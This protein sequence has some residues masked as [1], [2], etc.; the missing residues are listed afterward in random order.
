LAAVALAAAA[1]PVA[2]ASAGRAAPRVELRGTVSPLVAK[3]LAHVVGTPS[4]TKQVQAVV[5]FK[6]RN[7]ILLHWL[8]ERSSGRLGM[9]NAEI[10][11][12]FAP[13][14]ATVAAVRSYVNANGLSV[15][16]SSD[17]SLVVSGTAAAANRAFGVGLRLYRDARGMTYQAPS[18]NVRL[19]KGIASVV[20][21]VDGLDTSLR[22]HSH[23]Q[24]AS[25]PA[26]RAA[27]PKPKLVPHSVAG[28]VK[29]QTKQSNLGLGYLPG[30]L[31]GAGG[32]NHDSLISAG[33]DGSGNTIGFVEFSGY[34]RADANHFRNCFTGISSNFDPDV[35]V[36]GGPTDKRGQIEVTLDVEVAMGAA[37]DA[38]W[39]VYKAPNNL[40]LF[41]T[42]LSK[43]RGN[44]V[45]IVSDSWGLCEL[46]VPVKLTSVENTALELLAV[47]DVSF[48]VASG[49]NGA[50][51]CRAANANAKFL[52]I[53]DPSGQPF[54]TAVGGTTLHVP[55]FGGTPEKAWRGSGGGIS[56]NWPRPEY[57]QSTS[58]PFSSGESCLGGTDLCRA[59]PDIA[60]DA[61]PGTGYWIFSH[62][63]S[64]GGTPIW[65][66]VG[67]TSAAAPL[68]AGITA[69]ANESAG[70]ALGFA[71]PFIYDG[72]TG[73]HDITQGNNVNFTGSAYQAGVGYDFV[74][75]RG[76]VL[77]GQFASDLASYVATAPVFEK[78]KLTA[79]HPV[80]RKRVK[81]GSVVRFAGRLTNVDTPGPIAHRQIIVI[82][83][84]AIIAVT[85]S[86]ADGTWQVRARV[87]KRTTWHA[88]FMGSDTE[89]PAL[90]P[91]RLI[92]IKH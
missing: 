81:K 70:Q 89:K 62:G 28:C 11:R 79:T 52:A 40:A 49:D 72:T 86:T 84:G 66:V 37:P 43:M 20:Q 91:N 2:H 6:P 76:S 64:A 47:H 35:S 9:S 56:I 10:D 45:D 26:R 63:L 30:D 90:S 24:I 85:H 13:R 46:F 61:A 36:G 7:A 82:A 23:H 75:G 44:G 59:T 25:H 77:A 3:G 17:M 83:N 31:A 48:Y 18:G 74:T 67:G 78:T 16:D 29:A 42:M 41:P 19:P 60:L 1:A 27:G 33:F 12:L 53:D 22:A 21:S 39:Q 14:P 38:H 34:N 88:I 51:D 69:D 50:A 87:R 5:A 71:N 73:F 8:A 92:R 32:Y 57:Q 68:M 54:A 4:A 15:V 80:N 65:D 55:P 58:M